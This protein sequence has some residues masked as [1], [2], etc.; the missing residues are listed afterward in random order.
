MNA[1]L[2]ERWSEQVL[3]GGDLPS[4]KNP[5]PSSQTLAT[6]Q[7][8]D[9]NTGVNPVFMERETLPAKLYKTYIFGILID[10]Y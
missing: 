3:A 5:D 6:L 4:S 9:S 10:Y 1:A 8:A 7:P 2:L